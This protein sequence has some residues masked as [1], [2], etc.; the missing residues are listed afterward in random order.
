MQF[1]DLQT[2]LVGVVIMLL[3]LWLRDMRH[4]LNMPPGPLQW[5]ILGS[6]PSLALFGSK[7]PL[8]Y[9]KTLGDK[10]GG[11]FS[12]KLGD[13]FAVFISDYNII[14]EALMKQGSCFSHRPSIAMERAFRGSK[15]GVVLGN[16]RPWQVFRRFAMQSMRDFGVG[17]KSIEEKIQIEACSL[18][19]QL[20]KM[21]GKPHDPSPDT[22]VA[23][24]NIICAIIFG[25]RYEYGDAEFEQILDSIKDLTQSVEW[26]DL[27][28]MFEVFDHLPYQ[29]NFKRFIAANHRIH[30][31]IKRQIEE[32][33][34]TLDE[35]EDRDILD[36]YQQQLSHFIVD[37]F[38]AGAETTATTLGW[39][40]LYMAEH[41]D[42]QE[43]CFQEIYK[44][45]TE[46][47][48]PTMADRAKLPFVE[49]TISEVQR[50]RT[51]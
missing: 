31:V 49:A 44:V 14:K 33:R 29:K 35:T 32:H 26:T 3:V 23:V 45:R 18:I 8:A 4:G 39:A 20:E 51:I 43:K 48:P 50:I 46:Y 36:L 21:D 10:Y 27:R 40:Y 13:H 19:Q 24:T 12:V 16:G 22:Q 47:R 25:D 41:P 17:K 2:V 7:D 34:Q 6:L 38:V 28:N 1:L 42:I 30:G 37:L 11:I 5:P 15:P 9:L